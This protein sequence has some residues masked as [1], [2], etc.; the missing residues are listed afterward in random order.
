MGLRVVGAGL[1]RTGT[2]SLKIALERLLGG[3]CYHMI[4]TF[5]RPDDGPVWLRAARGDEPD[6]HTFLADYDATVDWPACDFWRPLAEANPEALVLL[7][8]RDSADAWWKSANDTIF[9]A[10]RRRMGSD[11]DD[12]GW[13]A[14]FFESR[15]GVFADEVAAKAMYEEHNANVRAA[16]PVDRL[17]EYRLGS[18]WEPLCDAVHLPVPDEPFPHANTTEDFH[19]MVEGMTKG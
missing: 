7:S 11:D 15:I 9:T 16:T 2:M 8:V 4:E 13:Q 3:R 5:D 1:G 10:L 14:E 17:L 6:W 18:G 19:K 12:L